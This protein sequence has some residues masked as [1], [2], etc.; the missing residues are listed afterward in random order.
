MTKMVLMTDF[1]VARV[2]HDANRAFCSALGD[3]SQPLWEFA[4]PWQIDSAIAG[5]QV[6]RANPAM[7][8]EGSHESWQ[9]EKRRTGWTY[10][11]VK[12][13]E[14]KEHPCMVP[15]H[16]LPPAQRMKDHLFGAIVRTLLHD[17]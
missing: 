17:E 16:E 10:G 8:P 9:A 11:P 6:H 12:D 1:A 14:K 2:C 7:T 5:V 15:Y 13:V 4:P 3:Q